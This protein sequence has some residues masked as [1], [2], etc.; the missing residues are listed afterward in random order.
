MP[1][2]EVRRHSIRK[3][4]GGSQL[5][6]EGVSLARALGA[7]MGPF[8]LVAT[9]VVPR[10]RETALAMGFAVD[11]ELV[12]LAS[13]PQ[14]YAEAATVEVE[15]APS[16][17]EAV[18]ALVAEGGAYAKHAHSLAAMWRDLLTPRAT[19]DQVLVIGHSG[20][21]EAAL[22]ACLPTADHASWGD[23]FGP[24]EGARLRFDGHPPHFSSIELIRV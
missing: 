13:D 9:S 20:D 17:F 22:V 10:S 6:Q 23:L 16:P 15:A 18:A 7:G 21:L 19:D 2:L 24:C 8:S 14:I 12:T 5:S 1:V 11:H 3:H 4:G